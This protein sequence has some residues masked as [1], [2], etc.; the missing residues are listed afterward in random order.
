MFE[1]QLQP[2]LSELTDGIDF[3]T[4]N[5]NYSGAKKYLSLYNSN[6]QKVTS[7]TKSFFVK[8]FNK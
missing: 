6:K 1:D 3:F 2:T 7:F 8:L 4:E 5:P